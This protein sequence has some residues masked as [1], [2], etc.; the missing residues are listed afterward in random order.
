MDKRSSLP[1]LSSLPRSSFTTFVGLEPCGKLH[2]SKSRRS[3]CIFFE[4]ER[5]ELTRPTLFLFSPSYDTPL[6]VIEDL[7]TRVKAYLTENSREWG[8]GMVSPKRLLRNR[9]PRTDILSFSLSP[10]TRYR[11][12]HQAER[13][14]YQH[15]HRA[16]EQLAGLGRTCE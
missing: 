13:Y 15:R 5:L 16:Q 4:N 7:K 14:R 6:D 12:H 10:A 8:G 9:S 11:Q 3:P 1:T 2:R